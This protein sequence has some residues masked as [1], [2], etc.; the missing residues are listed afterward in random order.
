MLSLILLYK[1]LDTKQSKTKY[2]AS[3]RVVD[4]LFGFHISYH[5][6]LEGLF[7]SPFWD[8]IKEQLE[9]LML[10]VNEQLQE[11]VVDLSLAKFVNGFENLKKESIRK[12]QWTWHKNLGHASL[13]LIS[14]L[15][16]HNLILGNVQD[17][18]RTR[19]TFKDQA[20]VASLFEVEPKSIGDALLGE[21]QT[22]VLDHPSRNRDRV[23]PAN[24]V[25][26]ECVSTNRR[27]PDQLRHLG[28][29]KSSSPRRVL[30]LVDFVS[31]SR[32]WFCMAGF[33][34]RLCMKALHANSSPTDSIPTG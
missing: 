24:K 8:Y 25:E 27:C 31:S 34:Y 26:I 33:V 2:K 29:L 16:K 23:F 11:D 14:K 9:E 13:R 17:K 22:R 32:L 30:L 7:W 12:D 1:E 6:K 3:T 10:K 19:S 18:V 5:W 28:Q 4:H 20:K 15:K 21:G